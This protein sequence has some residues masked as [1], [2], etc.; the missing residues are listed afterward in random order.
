LRSLLT[1]VLICALNTS[2]AVYA[3]P[4][5]PAPAPFVPPTSITGYRDASAELQAEK[6]FLAVPNADLAKE[7]LRILTSAPHI[8]GSPEDKK[9]AEYVLQKFKE[10]GL[11][12]YIQEYKVWMNLPAYIKVDVVAPQGVTMHGPSPEHV[13][14]DPYQDD[15]RVTVAFNEYSPSGD[16]TADVV[17]ANYGRL[18]DFKKLQEMGVD[19]KGK[20]A[21]VRYG[22]NFRGVKPYVAEQFGAIGVII[23][24]DPWDDGY[25]KGDKYPEGPMRPD[26]AVQRGS[27]QYLFRY[28]G[29][30]TTPGI[31]SVPDLPDSKRTPPEQATDLS[32]V[33]TTP[34]SYMD[35]TPI[36]ANLGGPDS[37]REWQGAL[38][39]TYHVG[40]GPVK[41]HMLLKQN[42]HWATMYDVIGMV[43][44]SEAPDEW[45]VSGNHRDAWVYGAVDPNSGT[46]AMLESV[47]GV[48]ELLKNGW[49]PKRTVMFCSWDGEEEG[50]LGSTEFAEQHADELK[51]AVAYFNMDVAVAG[52]SYGASAVPSLKQYERDVAKGVPSPKGGSVYEQWKISN[53]QDEKDH[54][55]VNSALGGSPREPNA[56]VK[57]DVNV[58]D[59]GS[60]SDFTPFLQHLGVPSTDISSHGPYGVYHSVFDNFA[61][62]TKFGDPTFVYEREMAQVFGIQAI[63]MADADVLP[64]DYEEYA[65]EITVYLKTAE[66]KSKDTFGAQSPSF[67]AANQAAQRME[68]AGAGM[69]KAQ[70]SAG[71]DAASMNTALLHAERAFVIN[72]LPGREWFKHAIYAPGEYTGYAAVVIP[73][74]NESIDRK[75]LA[76]TQQQ[77]Q[78]LSDAINRAADVLER[79]TGG[80]AAGGAAGAK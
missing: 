22:M 1:I 46:A 27:I 56:K 30:P 4:K 77:L 21:I 41:V 37:P 52:P 16:V 50:L 26:S 72:G 63:R 71:G 25:F 64:F 5:N 68:K 43:K 40:P 48:G 55:R 2:P 13:S 61:W 75:D 58:G 69:L 70:G 73:G 42:Y 32:K 54:H 3:Q 62:F 20:I 59:L 7:H 65:K 6:K 9:T 24:S 53:E 31:A 23:Y 18:E 51:N 35:A 60:G 38:P 67:A 76:T 14:D 57:Q 11:D 29:D 8:A 78:V 80:S 79:G 12:A 34:L 17:Y 45:V 44:G 36:M 19:V 47:H 28:P 15:P 33:P 10:A 39:F 66:E 74:V 49:R